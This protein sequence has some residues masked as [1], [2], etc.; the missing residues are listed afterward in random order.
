MEKFRNK[1]LDYHNGPI[2]DD[3]DL[4]H[5]YG[6]ENYEEWS[7]FWIVFSNKFNI[8]LYTQFQYRT[9]IF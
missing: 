4:N 2:W 9:D 6:W 8:S 3:K 5:D 7:N 1:W